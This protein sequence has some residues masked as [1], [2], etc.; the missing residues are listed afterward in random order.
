MKAEI[1]NS[2]RQAG[3]CAV[4][5]ATAGPVPADV[6]RRFEGWLNT[7]REAGMGYMGNHAEIR[8]D[9][10]LLLD[11]ARSI[12]CIAFG[13]DRGE[14]RPSSMPEISYY[15][16][17]PDYHDWV[18]ALIRNSGVGELLGREGSD[19]RICVDSAP[20]FERY[21]AWRAGLGIIGD[22]GALI[23]PVVGNRVILAE[24]ITTLDLEP[25][26]PIDGDCGHC[27]KCLKIC[28]TGALQPDGTID[29]DRCLSYL[30]IEHRGEWIEPAHREAVSTAAGR[31]TLFGC[32]RCMAI[33]PHNRHTDKCDNQYCGQDAD[34]CVSTPEP[35]PQIENLTPQQIL[36]SNPETLS[37]LLKGTCLKRAKPADLRRNALNTLS[38]NLADP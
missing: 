6:W 29:C 2:L 38:S 20:I 32:D 22:N 25:D 11:G 37:R 4:G 24:I 19:W 12:I 26:K 21:W 17:F 7:G 14:L 35:L 27:G 5:V 8:R 10:R 31:H 33:C 28:P 16:L 9:P 30:T 18:R 23:V 15:A 13:Y 1:F 36:D 34:Y 3:A